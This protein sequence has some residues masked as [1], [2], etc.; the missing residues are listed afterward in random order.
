MGPMADDRLS[1][2][3]GPPG[4]AR[5]TRRRGRMSEA[6]R[7][8]LADLA[9]TWM[10]PVDALLDP[11]ALARSFGRRAPLLLDVGG[12][13]GDATVAWAEEHPDRDVVGLELHRP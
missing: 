13:T 9:P 1:T 6:G 12:G 4:G 3:G 8:Q 10:L 7:A 5:T 11:V 2:S